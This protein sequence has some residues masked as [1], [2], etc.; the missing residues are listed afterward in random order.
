MKYTLI[1]LG[2]DGKDSQI[3]YGSCIPEACSDNLI[4]NSLNSAFKIVRAPFD[5]YSIDSNAQ[6]YEYPMNWLSYLT[7]LILL[8]IFILVLTA[9]F[10]RKKEKGRNKFIQSFDIVSNMKHF[11]V[12]EG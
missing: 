5:I 7:A 10:G 9:T 1:E 6:N 4:A 2:M 12:R 8:I 11:S 3:Y